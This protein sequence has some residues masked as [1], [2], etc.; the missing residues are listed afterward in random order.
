MR[1]LVVTQAVDLEDPVLG[2]FHRWLTEFSARFDSIE[3]I[4]LREGKHTL[5]ANVRVHSLGKEKGGNRFRY[6]L[7]FLSLIWKLRNSYD[8]VFVHMNPEYLLLAGDIWLVLQKPVTLWYNHEVGS[9][10]LRLA[11]PYAKVLF[12][13][14]PYAY[15]ARYKKAKRMPAGI[16]TALFT[17]KTD[18]EPPRSVY[19]Q[20]R[21]APAK[22]V[23]VLLSALR[24]LKERGEEAT[25]TIVGPIDH[26]YGTKLHREFDDLLDGDGVTMLG[27]KKNEETPAL[28]ASHAV[29]VNLTADGNYDK[30]VLESMACETPAIVSSKAFA[31]IVPDALRV[32]H[33]DSNALAD[34][35]SRFF[36]LPDAEKKALGS[37]GRE[38]VV[39]GHSLSALASRLRAELDACYGGLQQHEGHI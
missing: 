35:L 23:H 10:A 7:R 37:A 18:T 17:P 2:F 30:T 38:A 28:Y 9:L 8:A 3:V 5:P 16:D 29:S 36:A 32:P 1:L 12:H 14:S 21:V 34:A 22:N 25:A 4:C 24:T 33:G 19:F 27:P 20:G 26:A 13:T 39:S 6:A 31:D 11:A 15:T